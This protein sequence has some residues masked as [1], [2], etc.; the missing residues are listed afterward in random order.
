MWDGDRA[1]QSSDDSRVATKPARRPFEGET[2]ATFSVE[3]P[4]E[5]ETTRVKVGRQIKKEDIEDFWQQNAL[6]E[7][8]CGCY[9]FGFQAS[10]G[11][12]PMYVGKA[13]KSFK[14]E[15]FASHKR[16]V[17]QDALGSQKK[18]KPIVFFVCLK[19]RKGKKNLKAIDEVESF[20]IQAAFLKNPDLLNSRKLP[21]A[22]WTI[23]GI[24]R[25]KG[26]SPDSAQK[27]KRC[28]NLGAAKIAK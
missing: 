8:E 27:L 4:V 17:Y 6:L 28:L 1:N 23:S 13:T 11:S 16:V 9:V 19:R 12:K 15:I 7:S 18:G 22:S 3:G 14:Q 24:I 5:I 20:L 26:K 2:M 25:S 21:S 10:K